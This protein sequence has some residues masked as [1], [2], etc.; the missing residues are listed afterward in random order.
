MRIGYTIQGISDKPNQNQLAIPLIVF[1]IDMNELQ[2]RVRT[3]DYRIKL[4]HTWFF[5]TPF[6]TKK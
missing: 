4:P 2:G 3:Q 1:R 6:S 5:T